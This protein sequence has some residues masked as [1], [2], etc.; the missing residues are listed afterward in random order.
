MIEGFCPA[1]MES[2]YLFFIIMF[3]FYLA[4]QAAYSMYINKKK[5]QS[6]LIKSISD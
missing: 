5:T 1:W 3:L 4:F 6:F 2:L